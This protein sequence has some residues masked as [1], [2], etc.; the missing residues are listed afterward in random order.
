MKVE[1]ESEDLVQLQTEVY[2]LRR[3][4]RHLNDELLKINF[5]D[6]EQKGKWMAKKV[7]NAILTKLF[8]EMGF[9]QNEPVFPLIK[10]QDDIVNFVGD[11][12]LPDEAWNVQWGAELTEEAK[13]AFVRI[14]VN[15][16]KLKK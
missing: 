9:D 5:K 2:D 16:S 6:Y 12:Q 14:G 8:T 13:N 7:V 10:I 15:W 4:V 1:I 11:D 3:Q